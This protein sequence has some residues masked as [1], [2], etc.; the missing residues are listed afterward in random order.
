MADLVFEVERHEVLSG[1]DEE[2]YLADIE[3]NRATARKG[4]HLAAEE[5]AS[6]QPPEDG[7]PR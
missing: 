6:S 3:R 7:E 5:R 2:Q 1:I 4:R